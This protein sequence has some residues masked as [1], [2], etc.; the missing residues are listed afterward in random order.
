MP[1]LEA[2][3]WTFK[4]MQ[5]LDFIE[6]IQAKFG[7]EIKFILSIIGRPVSTFLNSLGHMFYFKYC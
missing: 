1:E 5:A 4:K 3:G 2:F 6:K 7:F